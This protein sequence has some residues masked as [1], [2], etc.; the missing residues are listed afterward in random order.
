LTL[1]KIFPLRFLAI[2]LVLSDFS[3]VSNI[4]KEP[5]KKVGLEYKNLSGNILGKVKLQ[6]VD[7]NKSVKFQNLSLDI[8]VASAL[9]RHL[10]IKNIEVQ[11]IEVS[12]KFIKSIVDKNETNETTQK[13]FDRIDI[14]KGK[15]SLKDTSYL[16]YKVFQAS[17]D[18]KD[19]TSDLNLSHKG[20]MKLLLKANFADINTTALLNNQKYNADGEVKIYKNFISTFLDKKIKIAQN[21]KIK[22]SVRGDEKYINF[23]VDTTNIDATYDNNWLK[24]ERLK[25]IGGFDFK[26]LYLKGDLNSSFD[27]NM[28]QA[29]IHAKAN[30][31]LKDINNTLIFDTNGSIIPKSGFANLY[32]EKYQTSIHKMPRVE[33]KA[34]GDFKKINFTTSLDDLNVKYQKNTV[35]MNNLKLNGD[36]SLLSGA[37]K[38]KFY[39]DFGGDI[40][41]GYLS[42]NSSSNIKDIN[43]TLKFEANSSISP[44]TNFSN[45][46]IKKYNATLTKMPHV[47]IKL[48]GDLK[49]LK[50][51]SS[52][53]SLKANYKERH[54]SLDKFS[55][56]GDIS[57]LK[58][59][60]DIKMS[61]LFGSDEATGDIGF[62]GK[63][64]FL[65]P[66]APISFVANSSIDANKEVL[67]KRSKL[68]LLNTPHLEIKA[69]GNQHTITS[70][71][72]ANTKIKSAGIISN[73]NLKSSPILFN[74]DTKETKGELE[75][76][77]DAK[78][79]NLNAKV[80]FSGNTTLPKKMKI[81]AFSNLNRFNAFGY[82]L[83]SIAP[84]RF[85][86]EGLERLK[87]VLKS[88]T[89]NGVV[90]SENLDT[91][92]FN[93]K[94]ANIYPTKI[95]KNLI[96]LEGKFI[97]LNGAGELKLSNKQFNITTDIGANDGFLVS[98]KAI[99]LK[100]R[101]DVTLK[102]RAFEAILQGNLQ[103][104][105]LQG[106]L[107]IDSIQEMIKEINK[108][109]TLDEV[110]ANGSVDLNFAKKGENFEVELKSPKIALEEFNIEKIAL[111]AMGDT[112]KVHLKTLS[113]ET[114]GFTNTN[115]NQSFYLKKE[116]LI[117]L[118][119]RMDMDIDMHPNI[120]IKSNGTKE[121]FTGKIKVAKLLFGLPE[122]G[123]M[124]I[125]SDI[126]Y[127]Q[128][129]E[130]RDI[131]GDV[132]L[133]KMK[134]IYE[135]KFLDIDKDA[136]VVVI[137]KKDKLKNAQK[138]T[139]KESM[140]INI[141]ALDAIYKTP[142]IDTQ[143]DI[144]LKIKKSY[145]EDM[146]VYG[147]IENIEGLF[148]QGTKKFYIKPSSLVFRGDKEVNP[149]LDIFVEYKLPQVEIG[150]EI[151]GDKN[152][153]QML[154]TSDP[155]LPQKDILSYLMLGVSASSLA[156]GGGSMSREATLF[157][158]NEMARDLAG[159]F[160]IDL[161]LIKDDGRGVTTSTLD[162]TDIE[163]TKKINQNNNLILEKS[164]DGNAYGAE[165]KFDDNFKIKAKLN[166]KSLPSQSVELEYRKRFK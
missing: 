28:A 146:R 52:L 97:Y 40:V 118:G 128:R 86:I 135:A 31:A 24:S 74:V 140:N 9:S 88:K 138:I 158:A 66:K 42:L 78:E 114:T 115:L 116:G 60:S 56:N 70:T 109:Y 33:I 166:E 54:F 73:M 94:S 153:P 12:E 53:D 63:F 30:V 99:N 136:D 51:L 23:K 11:N 20:D 151:K 139:T 92:K 108:L 41:N 76:L 148:I 38:V 117:S 29:D 95:D 18:L 44:N 7:Y 100:N 4:L 64:N 65:N 34:K 89:I 157:M 127:Q 14:Y 144:A 103:T 143:M 132:N 46:F 90:E 10:I 96:D 110:Q 126:V 156:E 48:K 159:D 122:M 113:F 59:D 161:I 104:Q 69:F 49:K 83:N 67:Q 142:N 75:F 1:P 39:S 101:L 6:E 13:P 102:N 32:I 17:L 124:V 150:I 152:H 133:S 149:I 72:N 162:G 147:K 16:N 22:F 80:A 36:F 121:N 123:E 106:N 111:H 105:N 43:N 155:F 87:V 26:K 68:Q 45:I 50:L 55:L 2:L 8:D 134:L 98:L 112:Q 93:L 145:D 91:F 61:S 5:L 154:F 160:G 125:D 21:P 47:E 129:G 71:L 119:N 120:M 164:Y 19:F 37:N 25:V 84:L 35:L 165:H 77:S 131:S 107:H 58:G 81:R 79:L 15:I 130:L 163:F 3:L 57:L 27:S 62:D 82:D 137:T 85:D 141:N